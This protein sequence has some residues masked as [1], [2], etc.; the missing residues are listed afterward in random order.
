MFKKI[1]KILYMT[2]S[3]IFLPPFLGF[4]FS[5]N[6]ESSGFFIGSYSFFILVL[7]AIQYLNFGFLNP[8]KLFKNEDIK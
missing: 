8:L 7:I 1:L 6:F 2:L 4:F 5:G 3:I